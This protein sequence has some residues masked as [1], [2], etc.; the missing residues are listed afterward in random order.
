M[1]C[2]PEIEK[3]DEKSIQKVRKL[4]EELGV[5][6]IAYKPIYYADLKPDE[7]KKLQTIEKELGVRVLAYR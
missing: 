5:V 7:V 6:L 4:E 3:L 1:V 2:L